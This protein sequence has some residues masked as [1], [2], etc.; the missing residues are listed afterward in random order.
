M[1][2]KIEFGVNPNPRDEKRATLVVKC[3]KALSGQC[4]FPIW[5]GPAGGSQWHWDGKIMKPSI[6]PS[7]DCKGGCGRHFIA[8][9]EAN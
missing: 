2:E 9:G 3:A 5:T 1:S 8:N 6:S 4:E 7:I